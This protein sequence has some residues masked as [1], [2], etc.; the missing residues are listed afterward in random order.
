MPFH[1]SVV[2]YNSAGEAVKHLFTGSSQ[3]EP[4]GFTL[5]STVLSEGTSLGS[6][7]LDFA[8]KLN[9]GSSTLT[10]TGL[11]DDAQYVA[12]GVYTIK[13]QQTDDFGNVQTWTREV[14]VLPATTQQWLRVYNSAGELVAALDPS[15]LGAGAVLTSVGLPPNQNTFSLPANAGGSGVPF[16]VQV[17][18]SST[19]LTL[20]WDGR[21][22]QGQMLASGPYT[23]QLVNIQAGSSQIIM[24]KG[25]TIL[26][27]LTQAPLVRMGPNPIGPTDQNLVFSFTALP[28][29]QS[30]SVRLYN[31]AGELITQ[32]TSSSGGGKIM[33]HIGPWSAGVYL[34]IFEVREAGGLRSRQVLRVVIAR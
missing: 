5:S 9:T 14:S 13:V 23:V 27:P 34:A 22:S 21:N 8:G 19:P 1:L 11:N 10:W 16:Q 25:F 29:G 3:D 28:A 4:G 15:S 32:G 30:A 33:L 7:N 12:G 6:V 24:S 2:L 26:A 20:N 31:V 18:G 17:Q